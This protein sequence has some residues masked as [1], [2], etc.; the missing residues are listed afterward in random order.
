MST[1]FQPASILLIVALTTLLGC[2]AAK[3]DGPPRAEV[4]GSVTFK[5]APVEQGSINLTPI[6]H[7]GRQASASIEGG[8]YLIPEEQGPNL[9]KYRVELYVFQPPKNAP[10][11]GSDAGMAQVAPPEFNKNSK[12]E[13]DVDSGKVTKDFSL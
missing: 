1:P 8:K 6:D 11:E 9:G 13:F 4:S 3:Y 12:V 7:D 5:G 2:S 10:P